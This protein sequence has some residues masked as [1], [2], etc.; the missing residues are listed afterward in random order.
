MN[1]LMISCGLEE[2]K[3]VNMCTCDDVMEIAFAGAK[4]MVLLKLMG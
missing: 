2:G 1:H 3:Y 4:E